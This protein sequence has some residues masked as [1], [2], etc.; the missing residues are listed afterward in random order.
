M[1]YCVLRSCTHVSAHVFPCGEQC[2]RQS[3]R[4]A[5]LRQHVQASAQ[6]GEQFGVEF[7]H[8]ECT[9]HTETSYGIRLALRIDTQETIV[10]KISPDRIGSVMLVPEQLQQHSSPPHMFFSQKHVNKL[11]LMRLHPF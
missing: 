3:G 10:Q 9:V 2:T 4:E 8:L 5:L 7:A 1:I 6:L 11:I